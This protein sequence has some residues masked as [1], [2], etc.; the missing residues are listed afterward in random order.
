MASARARAVRA[1][2]VYARAV[3]VALFVP[4][5]VDQL[6]P[7]VGLAAVEVL[8]RQGVEVVFPEAQT[9]CGQPFAN[10]GHPAEARA[11]GR[12]SVAAFAGFEHVVCPSGSCVAMLRR[13]LPR[14]LEGE[15]TAL[16]PRVREL[17]EFLVDVL[18]VTSVAGRFPHRVGL[19]PSCHGLREL[20]LARGSERMAASFDKVAPLLA[21]LDG[22]ELVVTER[23]DECCGFGGTFATGEADVSCR[24]G[25]D[26]LA[27]HEAA[28]A[29]VLTSV[30]ASCLLHLRGLAERRG[31]RLRAMHVAEI[32]AGREP[33]P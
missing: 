19:H 30:D 9:C 33:P 24:M 16:A 13:E 2:R 7:D 12:R 11:L 26:R 23:P 25:L 21:S 27:A 28:G 3:R 17:C 29:E 15:A 22:L 32:L 18:G 1:G 6:W 20:G 14:L 5:Y 10:A 8:E 31:S 4:C